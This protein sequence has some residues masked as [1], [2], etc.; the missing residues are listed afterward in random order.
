MTE[1]SLPEETIFGQ[2]SEIESAA[3]REKYLDRACGADRTLRA[4]IEALLRCDARA[5]DLLDL[6]EKP[7]ATGDQ[8]GIERTGAVIGPYKL[9]REIGEGGM[10]AVWLAEQM[11][12]VRRRVAL[13]IIKSGMDSR[14]VAA[15]FAAERQA[16]AMMD[17]PNIA[18]VLDAGTTASG[19]PYFAM[20]LFEGSPITRYC[21][22]HNMTP[23][24]RLKLFL[25]VCHAVQHAHQKGIIHRDLKPSNVLVALY[26]DVPVPKIIDFG[27]AKAIAQKLVDGTTFTQHG[28]VVGTLEY[29]SPE[30]AS[31]SAL[32]I[33]IRSDIYSLGVVLYELLTGLTPFEKARLRAAA[34]DELLRIIR[35]EE[36]RKPSARLS[37]LRRAGS[38]GRPDTSPATGRPSGSTEPEV[39]AASIAARRKMEPTHLKRLISGDL[40]WIVMRA[41]EKDRNRRYET[42]NALAMDLARYLANEPVVACPPSVRY[43]VG[44]FVRRNKGTVLAA[45]LGDPGSVGRH[46]RHDLGPNSGGA[47]ASERL[48]GPA[49]AEAERAEG[50]RRAREEAHHGVWR[51]D[52]EAL[53]TLASVIRDLDPMTAEKERLPLRVLVEAD[54]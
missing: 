22:D 17:H 53:E 50:E 32:D 46:F 27:V 52:R 24:D 12:P 5:G 18:K 41:L 3:E 37:E 10:G 36:P 20:E 6:P 33:D 13:K 7:A 25:P 42:A 28:Q 31:F 49:L 16:L 39:S 2:A 34:F 30:Q 11:H 47:S 40:D 15:R 44:K 38:T 23:H 19:R 14:Q 4:E 48:G 26:D 29:M 35:E 21:D 9:L 54:G 8:P 51:K 1:R 45:S 43:Q